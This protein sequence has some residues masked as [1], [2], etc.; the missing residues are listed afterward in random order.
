MNLNPA[1]K[2][3]LKLYLLFVLRMLMN[4]KVMLLQFFL[5]N[6]KSGHF[7]ICFLFDI[8]YNAIGES[9]KTFLYNLQSMLHA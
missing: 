1:L 7:F 8:S 2:S 3:K 6:I 5:A 9:L 4:K